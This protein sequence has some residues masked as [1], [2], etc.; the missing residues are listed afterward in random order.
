MHTY[1]PPRTSTF[2]HR[3]PLRAL[4]TTASQ[5]SC[6]PISLAFGTRKA[7]TPAFEHMVGVVQVHLSS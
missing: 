5:K 4:V 6:V 1:S 7:N 2:V 3:F